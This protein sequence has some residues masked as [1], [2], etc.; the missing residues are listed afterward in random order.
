MVQNG[1]L[2]KGYTIN[3]GLTSALTHIDW[4]VDGSLVVVNS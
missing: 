2:V 4:S 1:K 3:A